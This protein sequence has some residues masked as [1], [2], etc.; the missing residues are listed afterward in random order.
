MP[1]SYFHH[2]LARSPL[3]RALEY[4]IQNGMA[5]N[6]LRRLTLRLC[7]WYQSVT[8]RQTTVLDAY[9]YRR[10]RTALVELR[11]AYVIWQQHRHPCRCG[12]EA[13]NTDLG[14][15][16]SIVNRLRDQGWLGE[17]SGY[18]FLTNDVGH[19]DVPVVSRRG[20]LSAMAD[21]RRMRREHWRANPQGNIPLGSLRDERG[22]RPSREPSAH[23]N[24]SG[25]TQPGSQRRETINGRSRSSPP[26]PPTEQR[27]PF[28]GP[29]MNAGMLAEMLGHRASNDGESRS[30]P[31][32]PPTEQR[33]QVA[34]PPT[35]AGMLAEIFAR[36]RESRRNTLNPIS[37]AEGHSR[38][39]STTLL[40][41][42]IMG[43]S[44]AS[45]PNRIRRA[46]ELS[47]ISSR[48]SRRSRDGRGIRRPADLATAQ[49]SGRGS[50][51]PSMVRTRRRSGSLDSSL[52]ERGRQHV[53]LIE[54]L[55]RTAEAESS[56]L[57]ARARDLLNQFEAGPPTHEGGRFVIALF[58]QSVTWLVNQAQAGEG[59]LQGA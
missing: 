31:A 39:I 27:N 23:E 18:D 57:S 2:W 6:F 10:T 25:P 12:C 19:D 42:Q 34:G 9:I 56:P 5:P 32:N 37:S 44:D 33:N 45:W 28:A 24:F 40:M 4:Y 1:R 21:A 13:N 3:G 51:A 46:R 53:R 38:N 7:Y 50:H 22:R 36:E 59:Q 49:R 30:S 8:G 29:P 17:G 47:N 15:F 55:T 54:Q 14:T 11:W 16:S 41:N 58:W 20:G 48:T 43:Y 52:A 35:H 26:D